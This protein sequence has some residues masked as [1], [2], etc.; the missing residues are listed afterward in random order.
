MKTESAFR[1][2]ALRSIRVERFGASQTELAEKLG[3]DQS[4]YARYESGRSTPSADVLVKLATLLEVTTDYLLGLTENPTGYVQP[5]DL[6]PAEMRL[7]RAYRSG[8]VQDLLKVI[9]GDDKVF[10]P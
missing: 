1:K 8:Q 3:I 4:Q 2:E 6:S 5:D 10:T 9:A 7:I